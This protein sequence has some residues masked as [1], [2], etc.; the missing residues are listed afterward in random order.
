MTDS[1]AACR[2][3]TRRAKSSFPLAFR[4]LSRPKRQA[5]EALYAF[6]RV[7]DDLAD[8]PGDVEAKRESLGRWRIALDKA[9][10]GIYRHPI[11]AALH[12]TVVRYAIPS[13]YLHDLIDGVSMDLE[14]IRFATFD[15]LRSYC[16][17]VASVV[18]LACIHIW[19]LQAGVSFETAEGPAEAAGIAFQ[20]T[21]ILRDIEED[22]ARGRDYRPKDG[23]DLIERA[24]ECYR[25]AELLKPLL[26]REG[27]AIFHVM[28]GT[29]RALLE[30]IA[31][32][33]RP[34]RV[35]KWRKALIFLSAWPIRWGMV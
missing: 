19:G 13:R 11:H 26:S 12:D 5:M 1:F 14:P 7:T 2:A 29:Y 23:C 25:R 28:C 4:L 34:A 15:E 30:R 35:P 9:L 21:N 17:R 10:S 16:Y 20:L 8:E 24:R 27:R 33:S 31:S 32:G 22:A 3:I 18:G 6:S